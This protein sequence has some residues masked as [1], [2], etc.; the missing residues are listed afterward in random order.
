VII[1]HNIAALNTYRQLSTNST[2]TNKALEKL[3]SGM[4]INKAADDA[5]GL[6]IS[7]KMR[8][9]IRGLDQASSNAQDSISLIQTAEGGLNEIHSILQRM[10]ELA[11]QSSNDTATDSDRS[12]ITK[13]IDQLKSEINRI[14]TDTE[15]NT[16]KLLNGSLSTAKSAQGTV[17]NSD[18]I[19]AADTVATGG[20]SKAGLQVAV[21]EAAAGQVGTGY[22]NTAGAALAERT[23]IQTGEN[24]TFNITINGTA[25][26]DVTI[27]ASSAEGYTRTQFV[28]AL[29]TAINDKLAVSND[30]ANQFA[31]VN[32]SLTSDNHI[33]ITTEATGSSSTLSVSLANPTING[34]EGSAL[35]AMGYSAKATTLTGT[36][37]LSSGIE[38][39]TTAN[40][41]FAVELADGGATDVDLASYGLTAT[42]DYSFAEIKTAMQ[43]AFDDIFGEN[44]LE[45]SDDGN[46][47]IVL[48]NNLGT[49]TLKTAAHSNGTGTGHT[50]LFGGALTASTVS[51]SANITT[52]GT[53]TIN[54]VKVGTYISAGANDQF[55]ISVDGAAAKIVTLNAGNYAN[56]NALVNEVN[57]QINDDSDLAGK[58]KAQLASDGSGKIE[59]ISTSTGSSSSVNISDPTTSNQS[60]LGAL[61]YAGYAGG[62]AGTVALQAGIDFTTAATTTKMQVTLGNNVVD[63]D[64]ANYAGIFDDAENTAAGGAAVT[65]SSRDAIVQALQSALDDAFGEG[66]ITVNTSTTAAGV[67]T[68]LLTSNT[69]GAA[70]EIKDKDATQTGAATLFGADKTGTV[71]AAGVNIETDGTDAVDNTIST[72]T[73]LTGLADVDGNNLGLEAGNV[74][75]ISGTQNGEAFN[76]SVTVGDSSTLQDILNAMRNLDEF[77]GAT[78]FLDTTNGTVTVT[79]ADGATNDISNLKFAAQESATDTTAVAS[80]NKLFGSFDLTQQAQN[81]ASDASLSMH[82]GANQGQTL[83]VDINDMGTDAL[84]LTNIDVSSKEGAESAISVIENALENVSA[85]RS[86]LGALQNRLEH[87]INNL[88]TSSENLTT[89]ESRIRDVDM[90]KEMM[91]YTKNNILSQ[92]AQSMLAQANS[93]P[94]Q[95][96]QLLR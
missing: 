49:G 37:D 26:T 86:K 68:L 82:I 73:L 65:E 24:D 91:E 52:N 95:V 88:G 92:A 43:A 35:M 50:D 5:A 67:D 83:N 30:D 20:T 96:L 59:F 3:S 18:I 94:E 84:R 44:V 71:S 56:R 76:A 63:I 77:Q 2:N 21:S 4:R 17:A 12:E 79:G 15:F 74:I 7:E 85:E 89:S 22:S 11:V 75:N 34:A 69:R 27:D 60:A 87:T 40:M 54:E 66:A 61:G 8:A 14:S 10:R 19:D 78:V 62:L 57:N 39:I 48:N 23:I 9:Q 70:F 64:L 42:N 55:S 41:Q 33:K 29:N 81:Q 58:V 16:K 25:F 38:G 32:V 93:Q 31:R 46:G 6:A 1:N 53:N 45:V 36:A 47:H 13:E 28:E 72:S 51:Q 80:F 90:A